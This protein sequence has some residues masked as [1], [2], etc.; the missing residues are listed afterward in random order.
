MRHRNK[1]V[2]R[3][4]KGIEEGGVRGA[5][6]EDFLIVGGLFPGTALRKNNQERF[7]VYARHQLNSRGRR[8]E[9]G[10]PLSPH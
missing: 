9:V 4:V 7:T 8:K 1:D 5:C 2:V 10:N 3:E 6:D